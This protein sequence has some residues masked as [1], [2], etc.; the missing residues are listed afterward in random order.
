MQATGSEEIR[1]GQLAIR[2]LVEGDQSGGSVPPARMSRLRTVTTAT[3]RRS[4]GSRAS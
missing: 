1:I 2:F 3:T 4:T